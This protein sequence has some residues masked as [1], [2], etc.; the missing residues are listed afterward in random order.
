M[1]RIAVVDDNA[2]LL[3]DLC[4]HLSHAGFNVAAG[5][6]GKE[7]NTLLEHFRPHIVV[8]DLGLPG[9]DGLAIACRLRQSHPQLGLVMLTAR[10]GIKNRIAGHEA[11][12]D[13]YLTKPVEFDELITIVRTLARRL[14]SKQPTTWRFASRQ[15]QLH[16][17]QGLA[18]ELTT[19]E[20]AI[21]AAL[22]Q[23]PSH[24][25]SRKELIEALGGDWITYDE[26][27][28]EA[29]ISRLR[30]K[31]AGITGKEAPLRALRGVGYSFLEPL[32]D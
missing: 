14:G 13:Y 21:I 16:S 8:L 30:K 32:E 29:I 31:I 15:L 6:H 20:A 9:E 23:A 24:Q 5:Q 27:R 3:D 4:F 22:Q 11:G 7:L 10:A 17:P 25:A 26:R 1:T 19:A 12:A 28:L 2:D 18:L